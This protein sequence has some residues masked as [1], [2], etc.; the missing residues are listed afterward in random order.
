LII[1]FDPPNIGD[2]VAVADRLP[3]GLSRR[4]VFPLAFFGDQ[5]NGLPGKRIKRF[6]LSVMLY[7]NL[8]YFFKRQ[9]RGMNEGSET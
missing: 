4:L 3:N 5:T 6:D 8:F 2:R 1:D 9:I 7:R